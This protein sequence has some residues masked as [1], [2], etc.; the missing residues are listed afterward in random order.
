[1]SQ[2]KYWCF[3]LNNY[4]DLDEVTLKAQ[5]LIGE[6]SY[7]VYGLEVGAQ[8]TKHLQGYLEV[9]KRCRLTALKKILGANYHFEA[10]RGTQKQAID[11]ACK[12]GNFYE[13]GQKNVDVRVVTPKSK[14]NLIQNQLK[15]VHDKI[16]QG[17]SL[18][19][20]YEE[21]PLISARFP[22]YINT[23]AS[24][25]KPPIRSS[26]VV[27]LHHG[28]TGSGKTYNAFQRFPD[29]FSLPV[30]SGKT[31]WF[32]GYDNEPVVLMDDFTGAFALDQLLRLTDQYPIQVETKGGMVWFNPTLIIIT[33]NFK[34]ADWY[35][36]TNRPE[37]FLA[38]QRRITKRYHIL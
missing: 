4:T 25:R 8:G 1:M 9:P 17:V 18:S 33:S 7:V 5:V 36:Y 11:Y 2:T 12:E 13:Y 20:I 10:R 6:F 27:E 30:K 16:Q 37:H 21:E 38:L 31:L 14:E 24:L 28:P 26:L 22:K 3:T 32:N 15:R 29:L 23:V 35:T 19:S 34:E